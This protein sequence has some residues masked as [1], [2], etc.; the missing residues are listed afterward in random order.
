MT[1]LDFTIPFS[2]FASTTFINCFTSVYMYLEGMKQEDK[3]VTRCS[4]WENGQC[5][6]C[7]NC[8]KMC[9][10]D[11]A[12]RCSMIRSLP[13]TGRKQPDNGKRWG[14]PAGI[15]FL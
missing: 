4:Q 1:K 7:G 10:R 11:R 8:A 9:I 3:G 13:M 5:S 6:S 15:S 2:G 14:K 12:W